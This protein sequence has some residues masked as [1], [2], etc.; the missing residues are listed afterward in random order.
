MKK[1]LSIPLLAICLSAQLFGQP[2]KNMDA[3]RIWKMTEVLELNEEQSMK[4]LPALQIH[5]RELRSIQG[6]MVELY[7]KNQQFLEKEDLNQKAIDGQ[8][9]IYLKYQNEMHA[10]R[11]E[12]IKSLS[13]Y[14]TPEQQLKFIGFEHRFRKDLREYMKDRRNP[15]QGNQRKRP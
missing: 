2:D 7:K 3:M 4:F 5:E 11:Q 13:E 8:I 9:F 1:L 12:F 6:K 14:L 15:R 10:M